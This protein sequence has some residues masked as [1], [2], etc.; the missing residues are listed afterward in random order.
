MADLKRQAAQGAGDDD[1]DGV[2]AKRIKEHYESM[3]Q[4]HISAETR[5]GFEGHAV[6]TIN[7]FVKSCLLDIAVRAQSGEEH[8]AVADV[9]CGRG[10]DFPKWMHALQNAGKRASLFYGMDL[11]DTSVHASEMLRKFIAPVAE[12]VVFKMGDMASAFPDLAD[13][14]VDILSCQLC[15]H[16]VCD[17][18][19]RLRGFLAECVRVLRPGGILV[20]SYAD[21][22]S[23]VRRGRNALTACAAP[24]YVVHI[25]ANPMYSIDISSMHLRKRIPSPFGCKYVFNMPDTVHAL[26]EYLCHEGA[27]CSVAVKCGLVFGSSMNFDDA[28]RAFE[29]N[30]HL[31]SIGAKMKCIFT[32]DTQAMDAANLYRFSVFAKSPAALRKWDAAVR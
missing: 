4:R 8:L 17:A 18:A 1:D 28:A 21:G 6:K 32:Q 3:A 10:Q 22:R 24:E 29:R 5:A 23:I 25:A 19:E 7:N 9:A 30:A 16:Y 27:L 20:V 12:A 11:A 13:A 14:S 26:P 31:R 15:V 2:S